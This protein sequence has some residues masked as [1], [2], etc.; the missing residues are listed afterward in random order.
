AE[1]DAG[2]RGHGVGYRATVYRDNQ[3]ITHHAMHGSAAIRNQGSVARRPSSV[4]QDQQAPSE[5]ELRTIHDYRIAR[6]R[7]SRLVA[8]RRR[9]R[10]HGAAAGSPDVGAAGSSCVSR[11]ER[12]AGL[13]AAER[14]DRRVSGEL[15]LLSAIGAL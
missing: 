6:P 15:Q 4:A 12:R 11:A 5:I 10:L 14:E 13:H 8:G 1:V 7:P 9:S 2:A 3:T